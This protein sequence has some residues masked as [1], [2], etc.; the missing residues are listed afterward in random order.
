MSKGEEAN[1]RPSSCQRTMILE[2]E[3]FE[4]GSGECEPPR[5]ELHPKFKMALKK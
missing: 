1:K 5:T 2:N 4:F 3:A